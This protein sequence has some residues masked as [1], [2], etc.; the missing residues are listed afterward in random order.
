MATLDFTPAKHDLKLYKRDDAQYEMRFLDVQGVV[1]DLTGA[2]ASAQV[3]NSLGALIG[4]L[5][6]VIV[7]ADNAVRISILRE[8]YDTWKW[9][10]GFYDL[11]IT[12]GSGDVKTVLEGKIEIKGDRTYA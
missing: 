1:V 3:R 6:V 12:F 8:E 11:Q 5:Q 10:E 2:S 4:T 9:A 7:E